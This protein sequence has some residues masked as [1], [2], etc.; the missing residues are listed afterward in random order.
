MCV[1]VRERERERARASWLLR[2]YVFFVT[3]SVLWLFLTV[4]RVGLQCVNVVLPDHDHLFFVCQIK[5]KIG[6]NKMSYIMGRNPPTF[7]PSRCDLQIV[8]SLILIAFVVT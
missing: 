2:F 6:R 8:Y 1:C 7:N 3:V 5:H 4:P